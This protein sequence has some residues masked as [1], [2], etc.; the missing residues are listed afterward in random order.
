MIVDR[1]QALKAEALASREFKDRLV[2]RGLM[3]RLPKEQ[4]KRGLVLK[5]RVRL[6]NS[7]R[8]NREDLYAMIAGDNFSYIVDPTPQLYGGCVSKAEYQATKAAVFRL[9]DLVEPPGI[10]TLDHLGYSGGIVDTVLTRNEFILLYLIEEIKGGRYTHNELATLFYGPESD[11]FLQDQNRRAVTTRLCILNG[12]TRG[13][14][15]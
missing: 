14:C 9:K 5:P 6:S 11:K 10:H 2:D 8:S 3:T 1:L 7:G 13:Y 15:T 4:A 12:K